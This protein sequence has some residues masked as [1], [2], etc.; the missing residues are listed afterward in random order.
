MLGPLAR[1]G[2][3]HLGTA[4][5]ASAATALWL[6]THSIDLYALIG[7]LNEI[8]TTVGKAVAPMVPFVTGGLAIYQARV[9][10]KHKRKAR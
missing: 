3:S 6:A 8:V 5:G 1:I 2:L 10:K 9:P 4:I 7:E